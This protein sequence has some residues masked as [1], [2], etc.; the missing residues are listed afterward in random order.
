[1]LSPG[2]VAPSGGW[3]WSPHHSGNHKA[4]TYRG[5]GRA[6]S[7]RWATFSLEQEGNDAF[8]WL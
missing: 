1:M 2:A 4:V 3:G 7:T 5:A 6:S 8:F